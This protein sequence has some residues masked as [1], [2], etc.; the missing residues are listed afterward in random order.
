M[1]YE[2]MPT[3]SGV[4]L[5]SRFE[6]SLSVLS[7]LAHRRMIAIGRA[8]ANINEI[9]SRIINFEKS[10]DP[11]SNDNTKQIMKN[12]GMHMIGGLVNVEI[13]LEGGTNNAID[14]SGLFR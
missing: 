4:N 8:D 5:S 10:N 13:I 11:F 6:M 3:I 1:K 14:V 7:F 2:I 12:S 9:S